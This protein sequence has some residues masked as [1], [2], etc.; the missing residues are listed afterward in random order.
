MKNTDWKDIAEL[1]GIAAIVASLVFVGLQMRQAQKIAVAAQYHER[2]A[3]AV[4]WFHA[5]L[6]NNNG[7]A[8]ALLCTADIPPNVA[9]DEASRRCLTLNSFM[10]I[11][12]NHLYQYQSGFLDEESWLARRETIKRALRIS[13]A[14]YLVLERGG[15]FRESFV[16]L[17]STLVAEIESETLE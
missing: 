3:V 16:Q 2:T 1:V 4:D 14:R 12:D 10:T 8:H 7:V 9:V 13:E 11:S 17:A 5:Q 15:S 6:E